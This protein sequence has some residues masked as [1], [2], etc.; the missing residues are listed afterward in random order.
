MKKMPAILCLTLL[1]FLINQPV[2]GNSFAS[3]S[4]TDQFHTHYTYLGIGAMVALIKVDTPPKKKI[5]TGAKVSV[6]DRAKQ[7]EQGGAKSTNSAPPVP[8]VATKKQ[9]PPLPLKTAAQKKMNFNKNQYD[10]IPPPRKSSGTSD[11]YSKLPPPPKANRPALPPKT[12]AQKKMNFSKN[13]YDKIPAPRKSS[14]GSAAST[15]TKKAS[16]KVVRRKKSK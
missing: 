12:A 16:P 2:K 9:A 8:K 1:F 15:T 10:K 3:S 11:G 7:F 13:Q 6:A 5:E 4:D 14:S